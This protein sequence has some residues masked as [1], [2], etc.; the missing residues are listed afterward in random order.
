MKNISPGDRFGMLVVIRKTIAGKNPQY[1]CECDCGASKLV[2]GSG[3]CST[4]EPTKSCGCL[5]LKSAQRP[6]G[7]AAFKAK[8]AR[9][10]ANC[11]IK[12]IPLLLTYDEFT[13]LIQQD[14][15]YCG[16][17]P[18]PYNPYVNRNKEPTKN[19]KQR[20]VD[21]AWIKVNGIDR[22]DSQYGYTKENAV[23]ACSHCNYAKLD[24]TI[25]EFIKHAYNIVRHQET[26]KKEA[27]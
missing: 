21:R 24:Y 19:R 14:C 15:Y 2:W 1:L 5:Q 7:H 4:K 10:Q 8:W 12:Q 13:S 20:S 23:P 17:P 11:R 3:L 18:A 22:I 25:D 16:A 26:L 6:P 9:T 27:I